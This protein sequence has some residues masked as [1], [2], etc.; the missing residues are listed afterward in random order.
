MDG[1]YLSVMVIACSTLSGLMV[2]LLD[3]GALERINKENE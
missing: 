1:L 3:S 2:K